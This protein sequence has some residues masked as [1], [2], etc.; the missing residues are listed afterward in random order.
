MPSSAL[1]RPCQLWNTVGPSSSRLYRMSHFLWAGL[2]ISVGT[3]LY[4]VVDS[5]VG[6]LPVT[7]VDAERDAAPADILT[8]STGSWL[9][10]RRVYG[11]ADPAYDASKMHGL[12]VG[13][14]I[15]GQAWEEEKVLKIMELVEQSVKYA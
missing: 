14:Q 15:V 8:G 12:P 1:C 10:E 5:T 6:V 9:L 4:N 7:R 3:I 2:T 11:T 13:V